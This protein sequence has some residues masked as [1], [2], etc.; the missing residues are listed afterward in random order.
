VLWREQT[1]HA[2]DGA[3]SWRILTRV[4]LPLVRNGVVVV[5]ITNFIAAWGEW[6]LA[7]ILTNDQDKRTFPVVIAGAFGGMGQWQWPNIAAVYIVG[8]MPGL[9]IFALTQR[10]YMKGLQEGALKG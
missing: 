7:N 9:I 3:S 6:L 4:M 2:D 5:L 10:W 1:R 8:I